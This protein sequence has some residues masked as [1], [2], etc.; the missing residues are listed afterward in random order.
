[1]IF[2]YAGAPNRELADVFTGQ[3]DSGRLLEAF[4]A[5]LRENHMVGEFATPEDL[6]QKVTVAVAKLEADRGSAGPAVTA[7]ADH[8]LEAL[9]RSARTILK[10][11][12]AK[13]MHDIL[14][15]VYL[16]ARVLRAD[17]ASE[18]DRRTLIDVACYCAPRMTLITEEVAQCEPCLEEAERRWVDAHLAPFKDA[19]AGLRTAAG[20]ADAELRATAVADFNERLATWLS[21]LDGVLKDL[22]S[23]LDG[24]EIQAVI[25]KLKDRYAVQLE[26]VARNLQSLMDDTN[27]VLGKC[28]AL[29]DA[30]HGLQDVHDKLPAL[31]DRLATNDAQVA[32]GEWRRL[33]RRLNS[34]QDAWKRFGGLPSGGEDWE[35]DVRDD[36]HECWP[37]VQSCIQDVDCALVPAS[38]A[39]EGTADAVRPLVKLQARVEEHFKIVDE[40]LRAG[41]RLF[42]VR[43][44]EP[45]MRV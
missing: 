17:A 39:P 24:D 18:V 29:L 45:I 9:R 15:E 23:R 37:F 20:Q 22:A 3:G 38:P 40:A 2:I 14:H 6:A 44:G 16:K 13:A 19:I 25:A 10:L 11:Y 30:H 21:D 36:G 42:K 41:Y 33:K 28:Q 26:P 32:A 4:K 27:P 1:L 31:F 34:A 12:S 5:D 8:D 7:P 35:E 43:V